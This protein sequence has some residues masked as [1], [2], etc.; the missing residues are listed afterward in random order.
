MTPSLIMKKPMARSLWWPTDRSHYC[1][2][3]S[4]KQDCY[5]DDDDDD[6]FNDGDENDDD[7]G[8]GGNDD[9][10]DHSEEMEISG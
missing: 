10:K 2:S 7:H 4:T 1:N 9:K 8:G 6:A 3:T 5:D